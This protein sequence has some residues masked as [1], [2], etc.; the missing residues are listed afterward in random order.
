MLP[1]DALADAQAQS[2]PLGPGGEERIE[3]ASQ[4]CRRDSGAVV[5]DPHFHDVE[6]GGLASWQQPVGRAP[7]EPAALRRPLPRGRDRDQDFAALRQGLK[8]VH[9]DVQEHLQ[10]LIVV[11]VQLRNR[12]GPLDAQEHVLADRQLVDER[13]RLVQGGQNRVA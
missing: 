12:V 9:E 13:E 11:H 1:Y 8:R 10:N 2:R 6:E 4:D 7:A 3:D 5:P